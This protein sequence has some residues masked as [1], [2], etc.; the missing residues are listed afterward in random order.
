MPVPRTSTVAAGSEP[1]VSLYPALS[2]W[3]VVSPLVGANCTVRL[4]VAPAASVAPQLFWVMLSGVIQVP[5]LTTVLHFP[6]YVATATT[7]FVLA[8]MAGEGTVVHFFEGTLSWDTTLGQ[9]GLIA[10]GAVPGA[11]VGA[12][13]AQKLKGAVIIKA[14]AA[15]LLLVGA[16]L[17]LKAIQG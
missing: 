17:S 14:L 8:F 4:Q 9:A 6:V 13:L 10:L 7:Q 1:L 16:R 12:W 3:A 5:V 15:S 11:Q 2:V